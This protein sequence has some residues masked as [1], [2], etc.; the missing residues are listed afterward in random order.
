MD[1]GSEAAQREPTG[2]AGELVLT[3]AKL[4]LRS[5]TVLVYCSGWLMHAL[6][7][8]VLALKVSDRSGHWVEGSAAGGG[9]RAARTVLG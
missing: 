6:F 9:R 3:P 4:R 5:T 8:T 7:L 2:A 1:A